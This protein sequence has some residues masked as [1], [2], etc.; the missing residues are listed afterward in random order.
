M[1]ICEF[2]YYHHYIINVNA[3]F[4]SNRPTGM[5]VKIQSN[6]G[7]LMFPSHGENSSHSSCT[8]ATCQWQCHVLFCFVFC[9]FGIINGKGNYIFLVDCN[10]H[11]A[12]GKIYGLLY[13]SIRK[14]IRKTS[15]GWWKYTPLPYCYSVFK[16]EK[17]G[18]CG[19]YTS[20]YNVSF[21]SIDD[22]NAQIGCKITYH[23]LKLPGRRPRITKSIGLRQLL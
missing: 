15:L 1:P 8:F 5:S 9:I 23:T 11:Q 12:T 22:S 17:N 14:K 18:K 7:S 16:N 19:C 10:L 21:V 2:K 13:K 20:L 3:F 4:Q 6:W